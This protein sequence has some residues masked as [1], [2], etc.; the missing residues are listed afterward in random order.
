MKPSSPL[1]TLLAACLALAACGASLAQ[2]NYPA[3]PIRVIV[4]FAPGGATD[5]VARLLATHISQD[6]GVPVIVDNRPGANGNIGA[7]AVAKAAADGYTLLHSTSALGFTA[8][9]R[10]PVAYDLHKDL[11]PVSQLIDQPLLIMASNRLGTTDMKGV[12]QYAKQHPGTLSYGSSG[13][14]NLTH[15]AMHVLLHANGV[16]AT[17]IPYKGGAAAFPDFIAGRIDLFADPINSAYPYVASKR[18][19][20]MA[21]TGQARSTLLPDTPTASENML[22]GF[23]MSAWQALMAPAGTPPAVIEKLN[24]AYRK[25]LHHPDVKATL[26]K[27]G[28]VPVGSS[29]DDFRRFIEDEVSRWEKVVQSSGIKLD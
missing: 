8:A 2:P 17:H 7:D 29:P 1:R 12:I 23:H 11:A 22:P 3:K 27:Q 16:E 25:A 19:V 14:G 10:Q 5:Q 6:L 15:L 4:P 28:A 13:T 18:V 20:A 24:A 9:F 21:V 26:D